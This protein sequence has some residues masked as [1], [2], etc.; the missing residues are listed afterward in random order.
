MFGMFAFWCIDAKQVG[1]FWLDGIPFPLVAALMEP[2]GVLKMSEGA[3]NF[4]KECIFFHA[5]SGWWFQWTLRGAN[6][7]AP[8]GMPL[9]I[10]LRKAAMAL[11]ICARYQR[12]RWSKTQSTPVDGLIWVWEYA[13][14]E[15]MFSFKVCTFSKV[16]FSKYFS[17]RFGRDPSFRL[18]ERYLEGKKYFLRQKHHKS[19]I[20]FLHMQY[21]N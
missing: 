18:L 20:L 16:A 5:N 12:F 10:F 1:H 13:A 8:I 19:C 3:Q 6:C 21:L 9:L 17:C 15:S 14:Y 11:M 4:Y 2:L 7:R